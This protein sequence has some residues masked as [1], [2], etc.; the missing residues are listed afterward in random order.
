MTRVNMVHYVVINSRAPLAR[1]ADIL[2][3]FDFDR[4]CMRVCLTREEEKGNKQGAREGR[5]EVAVEPRVRDTRVSLEGQGQR[6]LRYLIGSELLKSR[7]GR[8]ESGERENEKG[9]G[10]GRRKKCW[11]QKTYV[12]SIKKVHN[13]QNYF[14]FH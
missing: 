9:R 11:R 7:E 2:Y 13:E 12:M 6:Y 14:K 3:K 5:K 8:G 1:L 4:D 10:N